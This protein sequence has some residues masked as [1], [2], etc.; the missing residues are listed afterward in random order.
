[1][2]WRPV[3]PRTGMSHSGRGHPSRHPLQW[4]ARRRI[5]QDI[6]T[7]HRGSSRQLSSRQ[8]TAR[9]RSISPT[10]SACRKHRLCPI[11]HMPRHRVS[12]TVLS[13]QLALLPCLLPPPRLSQPRQ[14]RPRGYQ[15]AQQRRRSDASRRRLEQDRLLETMGASFRQSLR[16]Q[17]ES[18]L[19][20]VLGQVLL[21]N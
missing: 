8:R 12:S 7:G 10:S 9:P 15:S 18:H 11:S 1:M 2:G 17:L 5:G 6:V 13:H 16:C 21:P 14:C 20:R 3:L 19:H 4:R